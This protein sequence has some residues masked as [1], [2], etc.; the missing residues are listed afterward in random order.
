MTTLTKTEPA[1]ALGAASATRVPAL[2]WMILLASFWIKCA[3]YFTVPFLAVFLTRQTDLTPAMIGLVIGAQPLAA[4]VGGFI[5]GHLSDRWGRQRIMQASLAGSALTY[6]GFFF[7]A[8]HLAGEPNAW[9]WFALLNLLVGV[10]SSFFWP[11]TQA[12]I[13]DRVSEAQR[14][15][16][17]RYRYVITNVGG[18]LGPLLGVTLGIAA[19]ATAFLVTAL[20]YAAFLAVFFALTMGRDVR[21]GASGSQ[22]SLRASLAVLGQDRA[23]R[24]LLLSAILFGVGYAQIESNL[25]QLLYHAFPDG[26]QFYSWI[27]TLNAVGVVALQPVANRIEKRLSAP[28]MMRLGAA[29]FCIGC[30]AMA[31]FPADK[32]SFLIGIAVITLGEILVVPTLSVVIDELAPSGMRGSYFGAAT[33]RQLGPT[34]GPVFGGLIISGVGATALFGFMALVG[35]LSAACL[36]FSGRRS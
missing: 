34:L 32:V 33:L 18:G 22:R 2:V 3:A 36:Q 29:V 28:T 26:L 17:Y 14:P 8:K 9:F 16:I 35:A 21:T 5:G 15:V 11:V 4:L 12:L 7:V 1:A 19:A 13:A 31:A 27:I 30:L 25:S 24:W 20:S 10:C 23:L 6:L